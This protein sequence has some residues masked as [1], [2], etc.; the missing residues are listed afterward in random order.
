M[1]SINWARILAQ[2]TYYFHS[3]FSI[4]RQT[5][6]SDPKV[7]FVVPT[8]N[9]GDIIAGY[10]ATRM[11]LPA[12]KLVIATN[13]NDILHRFWRTGH[14]EKH[15]VHGREAEG[16]FEED[17][18][19]AHA[20]GVKETLAPAMDILVSSNFE[21]L[22]WYLAYR[23][24]K[25]E[26]TNRRRM[27]AGEKVKN[28]LA[29]LKNEGG[30]G[31]DQEILAAAKDSFS[32]ERV[33]DKQTIDTIK[34]VYGWNLPAQKQTSGAGDGHK[35]T[36]GTENDGHYILDP[37]SAIG[38]AASLRSIADAGKGAHHISLATAH[39]AKFSHAVELALK[40]QPGFSFETVLPEQFVGLEQREKRVLGAKASWEAVREIVVKRV[41]EE[42]R[43]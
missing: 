3:Y 2:M 13:E 38:I 40:D 22:L 20:E 35:A 9:F 12:D 39:P 34:D 17:G 23:T 10:F 15:P 18:A 36:T 19:K 31:V 16:G 33:S 5:G 32:S 11:G 14:Y 25:T 24:S 7:R 4:A 42:R 21:R 30:F 43:A 6:S 28:W 26:E 1:N 37:H 27:E 41:E 8:G 29:Q